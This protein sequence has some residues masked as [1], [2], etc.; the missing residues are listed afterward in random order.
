MKDESPLLSPACHWVGV[1]VAKK[2]FDAA[3]VRP[4]QKYPMSPLS[5]IPVEEFARTPAG[6]TSFLR[7]LDACLTDDERLRPVRVVMEATG[8]YSTELAAWMTEQRRSLAPAIA[9]P[10]QTAA[11][12]VS[13]GLRNKTDK[14]EARALGFYGMERQPPPYQ[15][16]TPQE[17]QLREL[18]RYRD[19]L[20][21]AR[22]AAANHAGEASVCKMVRSMEKKQLRR[23]DAD[24]ERVERQMKNEADRCP[25]LKRDIDLLCSIYGVGFITAATIRAEL[26]DLRRFYKA[27]QL[28]A[29]AG[30]NPSLRQS[31][32]SVHGR[33]HLSKKGNPRV[34]QCLYLAAMVAVR[35]QNDLQRTYLRLREE[36]KSAMAALGAV[37]RKL[38]VLMR[39]IL[40]SGKPFEPRWKTPPH[41]APQP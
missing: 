7:W 12:M 16:M 38:L 28:T 37:M 14:L 21:R 15:P 27:R 39:A 30:L 9:P 10:H 33:P 19:F 20:V 34:R 32:S 8:R 3:L 31:G 41:Q 23:L 35:G 18:A 22:V 5:S 4:G 11:F 1:D 40:I 25:E 17:T 2:T 29:Y 13:L 24:I 26:G 36:G 6:V